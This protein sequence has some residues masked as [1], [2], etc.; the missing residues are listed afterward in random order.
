MKMYRQGDVMIEQIDAK[1]YRKLVMGDKSIPM[2][3]D[4][5]VLAY[6]EVTGHAHAFAPEDSRNIQ[7]FRSRSGGNVTVLDIKKPS[8]LV[9]EEHSTIDLPAG[10]YRVTR[11]RE[12]DD[13]QERIVAD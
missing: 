1:Q 12:W 11:Q 10:I 3:N 4:R 2:D 8:A 6:G 5:V 7:H 9:H 13:E